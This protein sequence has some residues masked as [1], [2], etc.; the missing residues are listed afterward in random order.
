MAFADQ[1][2]Q[3]ETEVHGEM[4]RR[5]NDDDQTAAMEMTECVRPESTSYLLPPEEGAMNAS[6]HYAW[7]GRKHN[8]PRQH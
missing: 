6:R 3:K 2:L 1:V 7:S 4:K 5:F 8:Y